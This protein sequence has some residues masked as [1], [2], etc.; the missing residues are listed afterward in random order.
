MT[1]T[2]TLSWGTAG[3]AVDKTPIFGHTNQFLVGASCDHGH[4]LYTTSAELGVF[5]PNFVLDGLGITFSAP[6]DVAPRNITAI[7]DYTGVYFSDTFDVNDRLSLTAGGRYNLAVIQL[8]DNTGEFPGLNGT[9]TYVHF[10]PMA[11]GTY[12]IY[13]GLSFY[14]GYSE[15]NRAPVPAELTC[16]NPTQPCVIQSFLTNDPALQQAPGRRGLGTSRL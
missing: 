9:N 1:S 2:D 4:T 12:K 14:G 13:P 11:G 15:G 6:D 7:N 10:N 5:G 3:Q 16:S 8:H